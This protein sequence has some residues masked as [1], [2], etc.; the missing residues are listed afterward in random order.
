MLLRHE[1]HQLGDSL[2]G[3]VRWGLDH[4]AAQN[5]A[6]GYRLQPF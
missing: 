3:E 2:P 5:P 6:T 1:A 4:F